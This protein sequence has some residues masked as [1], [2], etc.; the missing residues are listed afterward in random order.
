MKELNEQVYLYLEKYGIKEYTKFDDFKHGKGYLKLIWEQD[1][2]RCE[3]ILFEN[4]F[5]MVEEL[6]L[7]KFELTKNIIKS[8]FKI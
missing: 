3:T 8:K 6:L 7:S 1:Y 5:T 2:I 4:Q